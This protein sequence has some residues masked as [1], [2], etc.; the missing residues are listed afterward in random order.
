M[1]FLRQSSTIFVSVR[2]ATSKRMADAK[3]LANRLPSEVARSSKTSIWVEFTTLA[4]QCQ[5]VNLGQGFPD[6]RMPPVIADL[7]EK[8]AEHPERTDW[9]QYTRGFGH[10]RLVQV[11]GRLYSRMLGVSVSPMD[12]ILVTVGA[13]LALY[14]SCVGWLNQGDEVIVIEPAYDSYLPQIRMAGGVPVPITL[15]LRPNATTSADYR[16]DVAKLKSK[17][18]ERTKMILLNNPNNPTGKLYEREELEAIAEIVREHDLLVISDEVY[19][20]HVYP[21]KP[22]IRFASLPGMYERTIT[23]GS[24]GKAFSSTGWKT[25]WAIGPARLLQPLKAIHQNVVFTCPTPLQEAIA[26]AF[27]RELALIEA[28]KTEESYLLTG[29]A[30]ELLPK[31]D[32]LAAYLKAAGM[33]PIVPDAGYFMIADFQQFDGPFRSGTE[34]ELDFRFVRWLCREKKLAAIPPSA[35]YSPEHKKGNDHFVRLCF[36]KKDETLEAAEKILEHLRAK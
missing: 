20:W 17:L 13:Y 12:D 24:A 35:F 10:P 2:S 28:G 34:D 16:L 25:G 5:A 18:T 7:L 15:D 19:E 8:V 29:M 36:F 23:I 30:A 22:M 32:R 14:Y 27:E 11:L 4:A 21:G 1:R 26:C 3:P 31:R 33:N 6:S 9:H